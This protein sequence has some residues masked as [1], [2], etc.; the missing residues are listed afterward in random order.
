MVCP[1]ARI[2]T[3]LVRCDDLTGAGVTAPAWI[4]TLSSAGNAVAPVDFLRPHQAD[5]K[6]VPQAKF[7]PHIK[8][9]PRA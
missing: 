9:A 2:G 6:F 1:L 8:F 3:Q 7:A 5:K 4:P